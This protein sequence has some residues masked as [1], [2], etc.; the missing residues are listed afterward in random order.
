MKIR[1]LKPTCSM[2]KEGQ[3]DKHDVANSCF[4]HF[5]QAPRNQHIRS[6]QNFAHWRTISDATRQTKHW[7]ES[8]SGASIWTEL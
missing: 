5:C 7:T 1:K 8:I 4:S 2:W 3:T 6:G